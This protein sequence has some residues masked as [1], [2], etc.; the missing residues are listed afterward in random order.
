[1]TFTPGVRTYEARDRYGKTVPVTVPIDW[2]ETLLLGGRRFY[3]AD[4]GRSDTGRPAA[5][6]ADADMREFWYC[7]GRAYPA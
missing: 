6:Y 2:P 5:L 3:L 4:E 1:M 7:D